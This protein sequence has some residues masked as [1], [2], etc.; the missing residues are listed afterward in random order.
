[1]N[2]HKVEYTHSGSR[3]IEVIY[4]L[5][6]TGHTQEMQLPITFNSKIKSLKGPELE[7]KKQ[8]GERKKCDMGSERLRT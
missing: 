8:K 3:I 5:L 6:S 2:K 7:N 1:M 4:I